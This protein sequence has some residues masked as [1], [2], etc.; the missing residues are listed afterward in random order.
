[1]WQDVLMIIA[2]GLSV[3]SIYDFGSMIIKMIIN[4]TKISKKIYSF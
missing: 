1:M 4:N 3:Y 2:I